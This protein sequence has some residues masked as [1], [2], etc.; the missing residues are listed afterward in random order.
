MTKHKPIKRHLALQA[1][2]RDHHQGLLLCFKIRQGIKLGVEEARIKKYCEWFWK[3]HLAAHFSEEEKFV[4]TVLGDDDIMVQQALR[5]HKRLEKLFND[6]KSDY[7]HLKKLEKE[8][9]AHIRFEERVLFNKIQDVA[10]EE[11][12]ETITENHAGEPSCAV[13]EDEFWK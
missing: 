6:S 8:L 11:E 13:W 1:L 7:D 5:E 10:T 3:E 2:S 12:L 4:F 9:E